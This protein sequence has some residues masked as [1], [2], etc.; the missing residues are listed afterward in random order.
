MKRGNLIKAWSV[1]AA[2][3][4]GSPIMPDTSESSEEDHS[5][6]EDSKTTKPTV[7]SPAILP[8]D[9]KDVKD[10]WDIPRVP[11]RK[12]QKQKTVKPKRMQRTA[13]QPYFLALIWAI[14]LVRLYHSPIILL[15][16]VVAMLYFIIKCVLKVS[17][18]WSFIC[19]IAL[20]WFG[21]LKKWVASRQAALA[22][23]PIKGLVKLMIRGDQKV[24]KS[25]E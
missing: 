7:S 6:L 23:P 16:V 21:L 22:P 24:H 13:S 1:Q 17:G 9:V 10:G 8:E 12:L 4:F 18:L 5:P 14:V 15:L 11:I 3:A 25:K 20:S 19:H 2:A